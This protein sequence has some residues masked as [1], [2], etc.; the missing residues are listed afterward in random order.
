[1]EID[2]SVF[3]SSLLVCFTEGEVGNADFNTLRDNVSTD[4]ITY[5]QGVAP[6]CK[7]ALK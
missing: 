3:V 2:Y 7:D 1:M 5:L 6:I 4:A